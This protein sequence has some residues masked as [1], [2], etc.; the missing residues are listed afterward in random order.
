MGNSEEKLVFV[1]Q[2][3]DA[4][5]L[6]YDFRLERD[7]A[8]K[9]WAVPKGVPTKKG[10]KRLAV[11]VED[12]DLEYGDFE[13]EIEAGE[14]GAGKVEI[15]DNGRYEA[16]SWREDKIVFALDG[17]RFHGRYCLVRFKR[18]GEK[19]WLLFRL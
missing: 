14:Y 11:E 13:G 3:H 12:H 8:L 5:T 10:V 2:K 7:G 6:H 1:V 16:E 18:A 19:N 15:W 4:T 17:K 9:S